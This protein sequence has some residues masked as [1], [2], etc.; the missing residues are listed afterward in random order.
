MQT[1]A[2]HPIRGLGTL[3]GGP[4]KQVSQAVGGY[5]SD[6]VKNASRQLIGGPATKQPIQSVSSRL[7]QA[8]KATMA[9][10]QAPPPVP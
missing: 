8:A 9:A 2:G 5:A 1:A 4:I 3:M 6:H 7:Y 10:K